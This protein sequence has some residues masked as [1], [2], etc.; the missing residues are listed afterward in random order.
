MKLKSI[1]F[2]TAAGAFA[3]AAVCASGSASDSTPG[4]IILES[5]KSLP[6]VSLRLPATPDSVGKSTNPF[7]PEKLLESV[8]PLS[9]EDLS[10]LNGDFTTMAAD[11]AGVFHLVAPKDTSLLEL[12]RFSTSIMPEGFM[13]GKIRLNTTG[14]A[15]VYLDDKSI[16]SKT[17]FDSVAQHKDG[18]VTLNPYRTHQ[19][20]INLLSGNESDSPSLSLSFI[21]D[22]GSDS[23][24]LR[25]SPNLKTR[26][27]MGSLAGGTRVKSADIS[28][29]G[30]YVL[31]YYSSSTD[32][33]KLLNHT[34]LIDSKSGDIIIADSDDGY[35]WLPNK[36]STLYVDHKLAGNRFAIRTL[37][38]P[39]MKSGT[40]ASSLSDDVE[41]YMLAPDAS[42]ALFYTKVDGKVPKGVMRRYLEPDDRIQN[43]R[44]R[45]YINKVDL[46]SG[47]ITP[48]TYGGPTNQL[49]DISPDSKK[50]LYSSTRR[51]PDEF[52]F[53]DETLMELDLQTL[54]C[55]TIPGC[56]SS[57]TAVRYSPDGKQIL[58]LAGPNSFGGIGL[59]AG[60]YDYGNTYD[61]QAYIMDLK[62]RKVKAMTRDFDPSI[63]NDPEWN[64]GDG[65]IYFRAQAGFDANIYQMN[66]NSGVIRKL[67]AEV[68]FVRSYSM[69]RTS[70]PEIAYTGMSYDYAGIAKLLNVRSGKVRTLDD[71]LAEY[72]AGIQLGYSEP[73]VFTSADGTLI[74]G[75]LTFP[76]DFDPAKKYPMITYYYGGTTPSTH[77]N[78]H[79]YTPNFF[80][81][82]GYIVYTINPSGTIGYG[83]EFSA[84]HINAWGEKTADEIIAG[85]KK[86]C[87]EKSF[88]DKDK[89]GCIGASYGGFMTQL[90][91]T[92]TDIFAAAVSHAGISNITSYWGEGNWGYTYNAIAAARSYPWNN[93]KLFT[94]HS[95]LFA[96]DK[97]HTPLLLLHGT[98]DNNVPIGESIQLF[99]ALKI[100]G[101]EVEFITVDK[102]NHIILD[103]QKRKE[104]HNTIMAWFEKWLKNDPR[105][106]DS[107]YK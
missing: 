97:I 17:S 76:P 26:F 45:Y 24:S 18:T 67:N 28:P 54:K 90:L 62:T 61:I 14:A 38:I 83:Q 63:M 43:N 79:P 30:K 103:F 52:P 40:L 33:E 100:L 34:D 75:T 89:I 71:P 12:H 85:V 10:R 72:M 50:I 68:D 23:I 47:L 78:H 60:A 106:W 39:S 104:W 70:T 36:P 53:Y 6:T 19:I 8:A 56:D 73:F 96:A 82:F 58:I 105:W 81:S 1:I 29:D 87:S 107:L 88:I 66:P 37:E 16:I 41:D 20:T 22:S 65:N 92:K 42:F 25:Q 49:F 84:R 15:E 46:K 2:P 55:D 59:N 48:V 80:A 98:I 86:L 93:P 102:Q 95:P 77:T 13:K 32:G 57:I 44:D 51:T 69:S 74:D 35:A 21:P 4:K 64:P 99:N 31:M 3:L 94:E 91:Q 11:T 7:S 27:N 9:P 5:I 101:R